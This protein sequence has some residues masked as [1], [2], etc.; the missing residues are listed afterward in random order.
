MIDYLKLYD[1]LMDILTENGVDEKRARERTLYLIERLRLE[2]RINKGERIQ[3]RVHLLFERILK[4][5]FD[6]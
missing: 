3:P 5:P 4:S 1:G 6:K 2:D